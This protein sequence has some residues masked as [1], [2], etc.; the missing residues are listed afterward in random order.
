[1]PEVVLTI[2]QGNTTTDVC[3][4]R[5]GVAAQRQRIGRRISEYQEL[6][7][8]LRAA[9]PTTCIGLTVRP[10]GL[11]ALRKSAAGAGLDLVIAGVDLPCPLEIAYPQPQTLGVDRW[12]GALAAWE[13]CGAAACLTIE[14]GTAVTCNL[15][16]AAGEFLGGAIGSGFSTLVRG[17]ATAAPQLAHDVADG[18]RTMPPVNTQDAL[19]MGHRAGWC[20]LVDRLATDLL[21]TMTTRAAAVF[22]T[23]GEADVF[24]AGT[25][26]SAPQLVPD[27]VHRGL[28]ALWTRTR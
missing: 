25:R 28:L 3:V 13:L 17:L 8:W 14:S 12:V 26:L 15:I 4:F 1:M 7:G 9:G 22:V 2:D 19:R 18:P 27:L 10:D 6:E 23:G 16:S 21:A 11:D 5:D 24:V 20:G